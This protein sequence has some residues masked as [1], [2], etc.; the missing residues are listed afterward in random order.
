MVQ[1]NPTLNAELRAAFRNYA[2]RLLRM[3]QARRTYLDESVISGPAWDLM[4]ALYSLENEACA[5][6]KLSELADVPLTTALR[7]LQMLEQVGLVRREQ[8]DFDRRS[9]KIRLSDPGARCDGHD[10]S[11]GDVLGTEFSTEISCAGAAA[12]ERPVSAFH[13]NQ[14]PAA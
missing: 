2:K 4:V 12:S 3:R 6:G 9:I 13:P 11:R 10:L 7:R 14:T 1:N 5:V 8:S